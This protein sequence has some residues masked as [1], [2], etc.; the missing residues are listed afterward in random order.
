MKILIVDDH[1]Y[2]RELLNFI[3]EDEGAVLK[4]ERGL[5]EVRLSAGAKNVIKQYHWPRKCP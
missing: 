4:Q 2:N 1:A 5:D 3:L